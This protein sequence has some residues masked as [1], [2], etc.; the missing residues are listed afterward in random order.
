MCRIHTPLNQSDIF[1][2]QNMDSH[3][4]KKEIANKNNDYW[5]RVFTGTLFFMQS[6]F[7]KSK[8]KFEPTLQQGL[9]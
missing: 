6:G 9:V 5:N 1:H 2:D 4:L 8:Y 7:K 3:I